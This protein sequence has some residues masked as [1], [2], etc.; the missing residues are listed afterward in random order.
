MQDPRSAR[1]QPPDTPCG[2]RVREL[3]PARGIVTTCDS[4]AAGVANGDW[5]HLD[6]M[7]C[8]NTA[9][10]DGHADD[11]EAERAHTSITSTLELLGYLSLI[12]DADEPGYFN[13]AVCDD[14][15]CGGG[16]RWEVT[17]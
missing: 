16:T 15:Q 17:S 1:R 5:T 12:G 11:C 9:A 2:V 6:A 13:C 7:C 10:N 4:C 8:C 14:I 3:T